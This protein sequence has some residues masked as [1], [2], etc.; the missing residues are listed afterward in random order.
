MESKHL[1]MFY[2]DK[3]QETTEIEES[4]SARLYLTNCYRI[5]PSNNKR[6]ANRC[7]R[8][9][10][11]T[12]TPPTQALKPLVRKWSVKRVVDKDTEYLPTEEFL[13]SKYANVWDHVSRVLE[14]IITDGPAN[15]VES[16]ETLSRFVKIEAMHRREH[17]DTVPEPIAFCREDRIRDTETPVDIPPAQYQ[18]ELLREKRKLE[19]IRSIGFEDENGEVPLEDDTEVYFN[20][21]AQMNFFEEV[22]IGLPRHELYEIGISM[23][24][25]VRS[26]PIAKIRF[27]GK[28]F[29]HVRDYIVAECELKEDEI[30]RRHE[31][32]AIASVDNR[33]SER[34]ERITARLAKFESWKPRVIL[35]ENMREEELRN[36]I[37]RDKTA[38]LTY[39]PPPLNRPTEITRERVPPELTGEGCNK[40][41]YFVC[42][43]PIGNWYMLPNVKPKHLVAAREICYRLTGVLGR[44]LSKWEGF[45]P[46]TETEYLRAQIA[47]ISASTQVSPV[48]Y[49]KFE[50]EGGEEEEEPEE[51]EEEAGAKKKEIEENTNYVPLPLKDQTDPT[52]AYWVHHVPYILRQGRVTFWKEEKPQAE[53]EGGEEEEDE[54]VEK[55]PALMT[56]LAAD[57]SAEVTSP[58]SVRTSTDR[59]LHLSVVAVRS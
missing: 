51:E 35:R 30:A 32:D 23:Q 50:G 9:A 52:A 39:K 33:D 19:I 24:K 28:I 41:V 11:A 27:W 49:Y 26:Q 53:G 7:L 59:I 20:I 21:D 55:G 15:A 46:G 6:K 44:E 18:A 37:L 22:G 36:S 13:S 58:W 57:V 5:K 42:N 43:D 40:K 4:M 10:S 54:S 1:N 47:R 38:I 29:G 56:P 45:F 16:F 12:V 48:G 3:K 8:V 14:K 31:E 25:L 17:D 2:E 34:E